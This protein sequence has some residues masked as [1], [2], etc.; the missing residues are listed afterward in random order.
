MAI[1][2]DV[3]LCNVGVYSFSPR[4][5]QCS[6]QY[7]F[8]VAKLRDPASNKSLRSR[9]NDGRASEV[10]DWIKQDYRVA[11]ILAEARI[12]TEDSIS[13]QRGPWFSI[14]FSDTHG[15]WIS[16]SVAELVAE[17]LSTAGFNVYVAHL[18]LGDKEVPA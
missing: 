18:T 6:A 17:M 14:A 16:P 4:K 7:V 13:I 2:N 15:K 1:Y 11:S 12:L 5:N 10:K 3:K 9:F 8:D